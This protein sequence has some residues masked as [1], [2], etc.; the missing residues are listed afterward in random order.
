[1]KRVSIYRMDSGGLELDRI[2]PTT[3]TSRYM[4]HAHRAPWLVDVY[5]A[6]PRGLALVAL[7]PDGMFPLLK[8]DERRA[9]LLV[10]GDDLDGTGAGPA[11]FDRRVVRRVTRAAVHVAMVPGKP[12]RSIYSAAV[13]AALKARRPAVVC[14]TTFLWHADWHAELAVSAR[15]PILNAPVP[16]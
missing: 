4:D 8:R 11:R 1:M 9:L 13:S 10:I 16:A 7:T 3:F 14:E 2:D 6:I 5:D 12:E 15:V